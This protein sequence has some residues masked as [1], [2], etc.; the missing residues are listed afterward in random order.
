MDWY[1][2]DTNNSDADKSYF[3]TANLQLLMLRVQRERTI[4]IEGAHD[5]EAGTGTTI[6]GKIK[7]RFILNLSRD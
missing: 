6:G 3:S 5:L 4:I 1:N 7:H 2:H